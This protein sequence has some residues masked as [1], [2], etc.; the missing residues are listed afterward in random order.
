MDEFSYLWEKK[1]D[2]FLKK[3]GDFYSIMSKDNMMLIIEDDQ[4]YE[5]VVE[6]MIEKGVEI[7]GTNQI[8]EGIGNAY[9]VNNAVRSGYQAQHLV[10]KTFRDHSLIKV[11]D[12]NLNLADNGIFAKHYGSAK[13]VRTDLQIS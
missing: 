2:Y 10:P 11:L 3:L 13:K 7:I 12:F 8:T 1:E 6:K 5:K 4:V 9:C